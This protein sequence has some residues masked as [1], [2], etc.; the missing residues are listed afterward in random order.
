MKRLLLIIVLPVVSF[1]GAGIDRLN[2]ESDLPFWRLNILSGDPNELE[3]YMT[4]L[5]ESLQDVMDDIIID[6]NQLTSVESGITATTTGEQGD[7]RLTA[8]INEVSIVANTND[9]VTLPPASIG[10]TVNI[11]NNGSNSLEIWPAEGDDA[12]AGPD[13]ALVLASGNN[14]QITAYDSTNWEKAFTVDGEPGGLDTHVQYNDGGLFGGDTTFIFND[15]TKRLTV[16]VFTSTGVAT[17]GDGSRLATSAAPTTDPMI[18]NKKYVDD[19]AIAGTP[20]GG[21]DT[22]VQFNDGGVFNG[23]SAFTYNKA[24][25]VL[26]LSGLNVSELVATDAAKA[27]VSLNRDDLFAGFFTSGSVI[28]ADTDGT[29]TETNPGFTW[30]S[31]ILGITGDVAIANGKELQL[32]DIG[33]SNYVGFKAPPLIANQVWALPAADGDPGGV[34]ETDG[35]GNLIWADSPSEKV[36]AFM[37]RDAS[38]GTNY[39]GGYYKFETSDND[40]NPSVTFGTVNSSYAAHFFLVQAAGASGGTDTVIR[41]TGT[42]INDSG[43]RATAV[44]VDITVDDAGA[45]GTYYE[46]TQKWLGQVTVAKQSGPDLLCNYGYCKYWDD[47]NTNFKVVGIEATWLGAKND[48]TP[49]IKL[50]HHKADGWTYNIGASPDPPAEVASMATDHDTEIFI[51]VAEEGAWKRDNLNVNIRGGDGEGTIVEL[52]TTTNRTYAIGN[53]MIRITPFGENTMIYED[54]NTMIYEDGNTMIYD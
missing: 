13:T 15:S 50:R 44:D 36:W 46:T 6:L 3:A 22:E 8:Q 21:A 26:T 23:D 5:I 30:L 12:G 54:G 10:R 38:S 17:L 7:K 41:V 24:T 48:N 39:V 29:L 53:F 25:N 43:T 49:D 40:F 52:A 14:L 32:Y 1:A 37:S 34:L 35:R 33:S 16:Q 47:N 11:F 20:P 45:A 2:E 27:L 42:T 4:V 9:A 51:K 31:N 18:A 28:Y 19:A